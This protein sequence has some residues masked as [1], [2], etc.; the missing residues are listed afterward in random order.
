MKKGNKG[1]KLGTQ[2]AAVWQTPAP[3][4]LNRIRKGA[5]GGQEMYLVTGAWCQ[6]KPLVSSCVF[7]VS[8]FKNL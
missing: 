8:R 5:M 3:F 2:D 6:K 7:L 4:T 1:K